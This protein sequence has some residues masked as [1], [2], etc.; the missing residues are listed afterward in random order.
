MIPLID[1]GAFRGLCI[2]EVIDRKRLPPFP[3]KDSNTTGTRTGVVDYN[4]HKPSEVY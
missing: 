2:G 4:N 3:R 1:D